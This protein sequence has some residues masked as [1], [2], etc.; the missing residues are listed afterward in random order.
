[1]QVSETIYLRFNELDIPTKDIALL[2]GFDNGIAPEPFDYYI[3]QT[4]QFAETLI[5]ICG[6]YYINDNVSINKTENIVKI[7]DVEVNT[8]KIV[9]RM[10]QNSSAVA[11]FICT[12]GSELEDYSRAQMKIGNMPEGYVADLLGS[13]IVDA[14]MDKIQEKFAEQL[15]AE[16]LNITNRYSPGYCGWNVAEQHKLFKLMPQNSCNITLT[17]SSLMI[18][19]KSI[20]GIIGIGTKVKFNNYTCQICDLQNCTYRNRKAKGA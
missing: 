19:I 15:K 6:C 7:A 2:L 1:M 4:L 8:G 11:I 10:L 13:M 5:N 18:P 14:A 3:D 16:G 20:S 17:D 12:A 9:S